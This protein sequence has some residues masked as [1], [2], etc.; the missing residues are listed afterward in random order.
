MKFKLKGKPI[1]KPFDEARLELT[2]G[3]SEALVKVSRL[4]RAA[5]TCKLS[6]LNM[7]ASPSHASSGGFGRSRAAL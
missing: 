4:P 2:C 1:D 7:L 5:G 3:I 6:V